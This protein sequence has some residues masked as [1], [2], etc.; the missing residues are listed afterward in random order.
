MFEKQLL[1]VKFP[2]NYVNT[3]I[4]AMEFEP[5]HRS[6]REDDFYFKSFK[7]FKIT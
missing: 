6:T 2:K 5:S 7:Q 1:K 3:Y 4:I